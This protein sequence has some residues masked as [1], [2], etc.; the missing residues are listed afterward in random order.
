MKRSS[1]VIIRKLDTCL[2]FK[3]LS[4]YHSTFGYKSTI[5]QLDKSGFW[6]V[7]I[8]ESDKTDHIGKHYCLTGSCK[9]AINHPI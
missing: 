9:I 3:W 8:V 1:L 4:G 6:M 7:T 5:Q 2:V